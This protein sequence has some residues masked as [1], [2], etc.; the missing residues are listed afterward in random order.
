[1]R[2]T[3]SC[4]PERAQ[5]RRRAAAATDSLHQP[6][7]RRCSRQTGQG[8][9]ASASNVSVDQIRCVTIGASTLRV[10]RR[11]MPKIVPMTTAAM[12]SATLNVTAVTHYIT[13]VVPNTA[14]RGGRRRRAPR[15]N[16]SSP[17]PFTS[18]IA[19][20]TTVD[21]ASARARTL[22]SAPDR[23][24]T[25]CATKYAPKKAS[26]ARPQ[27]GGSHDDLSRLRAR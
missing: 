20:T 6:S 5:S 7:V 19:S 23:T 27:Q 13:M 17:T 24:G 16:S 21:P 14:D 18:A 8:Q 12:T 9:R 26:A 11:C 10:A 25:C 3:R 22:S 2:P 1:M 4:G 15:K